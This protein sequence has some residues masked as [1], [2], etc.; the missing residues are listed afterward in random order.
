MQLDLV[1]QIGGRFYIFEIK[2]GPILNVDKWVDR[3]R[4]FDNEHNRFITCTA[5]EK[6]DPDIFAPFRL[7]ALPSLEAQF[8]MM[9]EEDFLEPN[10][11]GK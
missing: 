8:T 4:L 10:T 9:L 2:S 3:S 7:F 11:T 6:L 1:A 5:N